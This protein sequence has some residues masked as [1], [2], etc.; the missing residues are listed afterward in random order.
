MTHPAIAHYYGEQDD[1]HKGKLLYPGGPDGYPIRLA[2]GENPTPLLR[3]E[4][5]DS[6]ETK[7][8]FRWKLFDLSKAEDAAEYVYVMDRVTNG[9]FSLIARE[10]H[11]IPEEQKYLVYVEWVQI[12]TQLP[13]GETRT[14]LD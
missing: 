7:N 6:L 13:K 4:E 2:E 10:R 3:Q 11:W 1:R 5:F 9:W 12:Y 14:R 8:D